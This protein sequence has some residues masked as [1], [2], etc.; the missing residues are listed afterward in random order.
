M[1][2]IVAWGCRM[3]HPPDSP[4]H[5]GGETTL[6]RVGLPGCLTHLRPPFTRGGMTRR[7][8]ALGCR[9]CSAHLSAP[10]H[11]GER[12]RAALPM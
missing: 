6:H 7:V 11:K 10:L 9:R 5:K 4:L 12:N 3:A 8:A 2:C 1:G